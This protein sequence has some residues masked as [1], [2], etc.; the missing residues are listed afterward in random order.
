M[1]TDKYKRHSPPTSATFRVFTKQRILILGVR[2][3]CCKIYHCPYLIVISLPFKLAIVIVI[4]K[5]A[6][7]SSWR[8]QCGNDGHRGVATTGSHGL[9]PPSSLAGVVH[10]KPTKVLPHHSLVA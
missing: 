4:A 8:Q 1:S 3:R 2:Q 7:T 10:T 5:I 6:F 9:P